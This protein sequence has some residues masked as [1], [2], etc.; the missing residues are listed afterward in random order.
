MPPG[1][2]PDHWHARWREDRIGFH[3][4]EVNRLL[5]KFWP[6]LVPDKTADVFVPLSGKSHDMTWLAERGHH[7]IGVELSEIA[8]AAYFEERGLTPDIHTEGDHTV[9]TA[10]GVELWCGDYFTFPAERLAK[11]AGVYDR[12]SLIALPQDLRARYAKKLAEL[13]PPGAGALLLTLSYDQA[14]ADGPPYSVPDDEVQSLFSGTFSV[15][16]RGTRDATEVSTNLTAKGVTRVMSSL[17]TMTRT[18]G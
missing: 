10:G 4:P 18:G 14:E 11:I 17:F 1:A 5:V 6:E 7:V 3:Q 16:Q 9:S 8:I 12:A 13:T 2:D 15:E